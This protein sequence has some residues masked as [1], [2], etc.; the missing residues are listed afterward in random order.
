MRY[1]KRNEIHFRWR[2]GSKTGEWNIRKTLTWLIVS[3]LKPTN[4]DVSAR[5]IRAH[6]KDAETV[7]RTPAS[8]RPT[9]QARRRTDTLTLRRIRTRRWNI[10]ET[11]TLIR[12]TR[13][14]IHEH[15]RHTQI[16]RLLCG[17]HSIGY[18]CRWTYT[19]CNFKCLHYQ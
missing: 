7:I 10:S 2:Y 1:D 19:L 3:P 15:V 18:Y 4:V 12:A 6:I 13:T 17:V 11:V 9:S 5:A 14:R 8:W 16:D